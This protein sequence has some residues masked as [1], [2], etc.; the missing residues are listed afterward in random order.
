[1]SE[2]PTLLRGA[3]YAAFDGELPE[4]SLHGAIGAPYAHVTAPLRRLSDRYTTEVC[5]A[6]SAGTA[7]PSHVRDILPDL[8]KIMSSSDSVSGKIGRACIDLTEAVVLSPRVG[9]QFEATVLRDATG[10]REA[11][12]FVASETVIAP[13]AGQPQEGARVTVRLI[14]ADIAARKVEFAYEPA[15]A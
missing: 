1:M 14:G 10:R 12:V 11:E 2:A 15:P 3:S 7:I 4:L 8:P 6:V 9:Q 5:L 13:C